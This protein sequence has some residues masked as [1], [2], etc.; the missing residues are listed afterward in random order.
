MKLLE[1][2][3]EN[4]C[5]HED[6][7][8]TFSH[9]LNGI[10]GRNGSG[11]SN[12][13]AAVIF[14]LTGYTYGT[15][16]ETLRYG[17][18]SGAVSL[19]F[20][21]DMTGDVYRIVRNI[22]NPDVTLY[23]KL[24][25]SFEQ[26][27][28]KS[29]DA[30]E[31]L[32]EHDCPTADIAVQ[33]L[34]MSQEKMTEILNVTAGKSSELLQKIFCLHPLRRKREKIRQFLKTVET[35]LSEL[36]S[37]KA[38]IQSMLESK[39]AI[40]SAFGAVPE[41][42]VIDQELAEINDRIKAVDT[43][44][45]Q[46]SGREY[47]ISQRSRLCAEL[48]SVQSTLL[49]PEPRSEAS[50]PYEDILR[51]AEDVRNRIQRFRQ[52]QEDLDRVLKIPVLTP[53]ST[54]ELN[55][56]FQD[57]KQYTDHLAVLREQSSVADKLRGT[58]VC[59][60]CHSRVD[61]AMFTYDFASDIAKATSAI[62][63]LSQTYS[64]L[65]SLSER[66]RT[67]QAE[68][69]A[70]YS[71]IYATSE[72]LGW[73]L[74]GSPS[75]ELKR[76]DSEIDELNTLYQALFKESKKAEEYRQEYSAWTS[77]QTAA[78]SRLKAIEDELT[79][80]DSNPLLTAVIDRSLVDLHSDRDKLVAQHNAVKDQ[81]I[82]RAKFD[83]AAA[84]IENLN[85]RKLEV[86]NLLKEYHQDTAELLKDLTAWLSP[87]E[88]PQRV[89]STLYRILSDKINEC[90]LE[91]NSPYTVD[92]LQTG[93]FS[94]SRGD[95]MVQSASRLSGGEKMVISIAF[96][97]ALHE[98]FSSNDNA[99]FLMLDEPTTFLDANNQTVLYAALQ[100]LKSSPRFD[101][102]QIFVVTHEDNLKPLFD[103]VISL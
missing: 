57:L 67:C 53:P 29:A 35:R 66:A 51:E 62:D 26:V 4:W 5:Q 46:I 81:L 11:K 100:R 1:L 23:K 90:L 34:A 61:P 28:R 17:A 27:S 58:G 3:A 82:S 71:H 68:T 32:E 65:M 63:I 20:K 70:L 6:I 92:I 22:H 87:S 31:F 8:V 103:N 78:Q 37:N 18:R 54:E 79:S 89:A 91:F 42:S 83:S 97:L 96:R 60:T 56:A 41:K 94:C 2:K 75:D 74:S 59:P 15:R 47:L 19:T 64:D 43:V 98:L 33:V 55:K 102:M 86:E 77:R 95:G 10:F 72:R 44:I 93:E 69:Q 80:I 7:S 48:S 50:K 36:V 84:E 49:E 85:S 24:G 9:G 14:A 16:A 99:G 38:L 101:S 13:F 45:G 40:I 12:L 25:D 76:I 52:I 73:Q 88:F 21:L 30:R 39:L